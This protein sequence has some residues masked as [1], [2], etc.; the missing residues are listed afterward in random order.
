MQRINIPAGKRQELSFAYGR[1]LERM[2]SSGKEAHMTPVGRRT[3]YDNFLYAIVV[4]SE[5]APITVVS[6][7][8]RLN[9]DPW[10]EASRLAQLP[11]QEAIDWLSGNIQRV[12]T[13]RMPEAAEIASRLLQRLPTREN[14]VVQAMRTETLDF[15]SIW[16]IFAIFFTMMIVS[17][18][19]QRP[20][21]VPP[22]ER[23]T[24][25]K[26]APAILPHD[27]ARK[28]DRQSVQ[29]MHPQH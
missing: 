4:E 20:D 10:L 21:G 5:G 2:H 11:R 25:Q 13:R 27:D 23:A 15:T 18:G 8:T 22:R 28:R 26:S 12:T 1:A 19:V 9:L 17:S 14:L 29:P 16:L 3:S 7:L 6:M 24:V